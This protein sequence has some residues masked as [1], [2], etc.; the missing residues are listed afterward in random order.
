MAHV[1]SERFFFSISDRPIT[2]SGCL[3]ASNVETRNLQV[4]QTTTSWPATNRLVGWLVDW[5][6][7][8]KLLHIHMYIQILKY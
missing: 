7:W 6:G 1:V 3:V 8:E 4:P 2:P 5:M